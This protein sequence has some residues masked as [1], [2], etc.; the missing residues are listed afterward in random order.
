MK[1]THMKFSEPLKKGAH[2]LY[3]A[4][5]GWEFY[6][7][8]GR[9]D[10]NNPTGDFLGLSPRQAYIEMFNALEKLHGP[11]ALG[12]IMRKRIVRNSF[13]GVVVCSDGGRL[14]DLVPIIEHVGEKNVLIVEIHA[15]GV[16]FDTHNDIRYYVGEEVLE[17]YPKVT[18]KKLP[19]RIGGRSDKEIF[20]ILC[21]GVVKV[22]L[23]IEE[24]E[25]A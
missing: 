18:V 21:Q 16:T 25:N 15:T 22:W 6:D 2:A 19:N 9:K 14:A 20:K 8:D 1:P 12:Y 17:K 5:H 4:F 23:D 3:S 11:E 13:A 10:K 7:E 24:K